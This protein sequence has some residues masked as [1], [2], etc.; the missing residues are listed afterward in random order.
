MV[1]EILKIIMKS[2]TLFLN[3]LNLRRK[4]TALICNFLALISMYLNFSFSITLVISMKS[5]VM[6][7]VYPLQNF[8]TFVAICFKYLY[9]LLH[10]LRFSRCSVSAHAQNV[11]KFQMF[12]ILLSILYQFIMVKYFH[13]FYIFQKSYYYESWRF[14]ISYCFQ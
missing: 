7:N 9:V 3:N 8:I 13:I 4:I 2:N 6:P 12:E 14:A 1:I 10:F 11:E 5:L